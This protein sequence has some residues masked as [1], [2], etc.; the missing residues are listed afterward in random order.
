[1][2]EPVLLPWV[3]QR[4]DNGH[5]LR[6][7]DAGRRN[8]RTR[9]ARVGAELS[10]ATRPSTHDAWSAPVN[11]GPPVNTTFAEFQPDLSHDGRTLLF[12]AGVAR[13]GLGGFDIWMSTRTVNG[14]E[15]P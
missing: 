13:G 5:L 1:M 11:L 8:A 2:R 9:G 3:R 7:G 15:E 14:K 4:R 10:R 12:I 6:A